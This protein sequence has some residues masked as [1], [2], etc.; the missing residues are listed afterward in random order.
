MRIPGRIIV[1]V[2]EIKTSASDSGCRLIGNKKSQG[3]T[4]PT[5]EIQAA[6]HKGVLDTHQV[7]ANSG[8]L[9]TNSLVLILENISLF[10][11]S[12]RSYCLNITLAN[13]IGFISA[14]GKDYIRME[15]PSLMHALQVEALHVEVALQDFDDFEFDD[16]DDGFF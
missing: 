1:M 7:Q 14:Q 10:K 13:V 16:L 4:D 8:K 12:Q 11:L 15:D 2:K 3:L 6:I 5:G 9:Y